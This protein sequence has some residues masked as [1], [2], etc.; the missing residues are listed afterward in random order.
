MAAY[1]A[2]D[3][4]NVPLFQGLRVRQGD[5]LFCGR[6]GG[7]CGVG[8][9]ETKGRGE[10]GVFDEH[11]GAGRVLEMGQGLEVCG[12]LGQRGL[13]SGGTGHQPAQAQHRRQ[14][15]GRQG[16]SPP[17]G[18]R[19]K[20]IVKSLFHHRNSSLPWS[21]QGCGGGGRGFQGGQKGPGVGAPLDWGGAC[22]H[23]IVA[24]QLQIPGGLPGHLMDQ[25]VEPVDS[26]GQKEQKLAPQM[27]PGLVGQLVAKNPG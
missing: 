17:T 12:F 4:H 10:L 18:E 26:P 3:Q 6:T 27:P 8:G 16:P 11:A 9:G 7:V 13:G 14:S 19:G 5:H 1:A 23:P 2:H 15:N 25:G 21:G 20:E 24:G 22:H